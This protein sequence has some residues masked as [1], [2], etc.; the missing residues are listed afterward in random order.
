MGFPGE[1]ERTKKVFYEEVSDY[2]NFLF[3]DLI[4]KYSDIITNRRL[5]LNIVQLVLRIV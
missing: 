4:L 3:R 2:T 5:R 1:V